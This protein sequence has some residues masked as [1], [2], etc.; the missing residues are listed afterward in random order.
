MMTQKLRVDDAVMINHLKPHPCH[1][2]SPPYRLCQQLSHLINIQTFRTRD[3]NKLHIITS[4]DS[5]PK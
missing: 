1:T 5:S 2:K 4:Q 3:V